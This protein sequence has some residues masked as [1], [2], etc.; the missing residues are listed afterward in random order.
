MFQPSV[1]LSVP[2]TAAVRIKLCEEY[3]VCIRSFVF[4]MSEK[5]VEKKCI[6]HHF[7]LAVRLH[8]HRKKVIVG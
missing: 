8:L 2:N 4:V 7:H 6:F 3:M 5:N 1:F